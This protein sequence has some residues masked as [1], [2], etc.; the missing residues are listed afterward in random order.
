MFKASSLFELIVLNKIN[1]DQTRHHQARDIYIVLKEKVK[2]KEESGEQVVLP[3][4]MREYS[5]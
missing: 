5:R 4:L 1:F 3:S 2:E